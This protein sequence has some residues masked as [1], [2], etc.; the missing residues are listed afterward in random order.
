MIFVTGELSVY[1]LFT[2][3]TPRGETNPWIS[4]WFFFLWTP[5]F[6]DTGINFLC[7]KTYATTRPS[8]TYSNET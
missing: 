7:D 1:D 3:N 6:E 4:Q 2:V 5:F 8:Q